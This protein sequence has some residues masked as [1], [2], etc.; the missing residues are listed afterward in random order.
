MIR[1]YLKRLIRLIKL[2]YHEL[3]FP[4][5]KKV[6]ANIVTLAPNSLLEGRTA[7]ITG[8]TSGI[9]LAIAKAFLNA[10]ASVVAIGR[11]KEK[12]DA[13]VQTLLPCSKNDAK[14]YSYVLDVTEIDKLDIAVQEI[15]EMVANHQI[16]ILVNNA[17][18]ALVPSVSPKQEFDIVMNTNLKAVFFLSKCVARHMINNQIE[19][20]ILNI[21]SSS[22]LRP[23]NHAYALSKWG[24][25]GLTEG[26]AKMLIKH[27]I[28]VNGIGPCGT[29]TPFMGMTNNEELLSKTIPAQRLATPEEVANI[30]VVLT[31]GMGRMIVG[32]I[33][34]LSGGAGVITC[35]DVDYDF[36]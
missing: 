10:G 35:D 24:I 19:G 8:C 7:A 5:R 22:S 26:F 33:I 23:A 11:N 29:A 13:A 2:I 34:Y 20:N 12:L 4:L 16:D 27:N 21:A 31:S 25:R 14:V 17:G 6:S 32:D 1:R 36:N 15:V 28:V 3:V 30:A 18:L 9:G